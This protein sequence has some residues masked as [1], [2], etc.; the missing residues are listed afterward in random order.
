MADDGKTGKM[1]A[2]REALELDIVDDILETDEKGIFIVERKKTPG[3]M[4]FCNDVPQD[5][6]EVYLVLGPSE[7]DDDV[8]RRPDYEIRGYRVYRE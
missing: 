5:F 6:L 3:L 8:D 7:E 1:R 2:L 4:G